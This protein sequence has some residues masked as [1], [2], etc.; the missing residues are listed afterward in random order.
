LKK[1][2]SKSIA[3]SHPSFNVHWSSPSSSYCNDNKHK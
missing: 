2:P 3:L 1:Y